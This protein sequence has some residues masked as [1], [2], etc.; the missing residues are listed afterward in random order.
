MN[1]E[2]QRARLAAILAPRGNRP[3]TSRDRELWQQLPHDRSGQRVVKRSR[4]CCIKWSHNTEQENK[5]DER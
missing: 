2:T 4:I 3:L 1:L 5:E